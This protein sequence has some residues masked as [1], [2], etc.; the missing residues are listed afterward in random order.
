M[1]RKR[2]RKKTKETSA[3]P[4]ELTGI[5]RLLVESPVESLDLHGMNA[6]QAETRVQFFFQ[7]HAT[8]SPGRVVHIIT[9]RG[10][11]SEGAPVLPDL[12]REMLQHDLSGMVSEWAGLHGGGGFA[13][14][15]TGS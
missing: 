3:S 11:R 8:T 2:K 1:P 10:T 5:A 9:G 12:V 14:R 15:I 7:R 4:P 6:G 13:A